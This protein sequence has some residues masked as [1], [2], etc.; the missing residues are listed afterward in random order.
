MKFTVKVLS[1]LFGL[2]LTTGLGVAQTMPEPGPEHAWLQQ[3]V[4][5][6]AA[7]T[8]AYVEP[9]KAPMRSES[10]EHIRPLGGFWTIAEVESTV[11]DKP[12]NAQMTLGYDDVQKQF[13]GTWID[14][15]TGHMWQYQGALDESGKTLTLESEG[16][17]P[18]RPGKLTRVKEVIRLADPDHKDY[19]SYMMGDDGQWVKVLS[20]RAERVK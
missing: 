3:F 4:G 12:F 5:E 8:E 7:D 2:M 11:M 14:S 10:T 13:V 16:M 1:A 6:W 19:T 20:S 9:G 18:M 15:M 17:C